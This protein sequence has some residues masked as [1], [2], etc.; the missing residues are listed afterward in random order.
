M[1]QLAGLIGVNA[2]RVVCANSEQYRVTVARGRAVQ[3]TRVAP[4]EPR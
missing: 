3:P 2:I 4:H 1:S